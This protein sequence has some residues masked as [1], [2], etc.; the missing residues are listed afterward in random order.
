MQSDALRG[1]YKLV[2]R[3][4]F[5]LGIGFNVREQS[6]FLEQLHRHAHLEVLLMVAKFLL[7]LALAESISCQYLS[8][9]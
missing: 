6:L 5:L 7:D 2:A 8:G 4:R 9:R 3:T 1:Q